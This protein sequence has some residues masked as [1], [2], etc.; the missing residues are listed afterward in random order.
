MSEITKETVK[1]TINGKE[2]ELPSDMTILEA[3]RHV[4]VPIPT[5]C[6]SESVT[7]YGAC[8]FCT[9]EVTKRGRK[10]YV[11]ACL[12]PVGDLEVRTDTEEIRQA[13]KTLLEF[14][15]ARS[16]QAPE[17]LELYREY[18]GG[19]SAPFSIVDNHG[20]DNCILCG[21]CARVCDEIVGAAAVGFAGRGIKKEV[22]PGMLRASDKCIGC[23]TCVYVCPTDSIRVADINSVYSEHKWPNEL[24]HRH[25]RACAGIHVEPEFFKELEVLVQVPKGSEQ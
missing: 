23:G 2:I 15:L 4:G 13:R 19:D 25:C 17:L 9:V 8:R 14:Y 6:F 22:A 21:L 16:P 10:K 3:A 12:H 11:V 1:M 24:S 7:Q 5:L 18:G 20:E